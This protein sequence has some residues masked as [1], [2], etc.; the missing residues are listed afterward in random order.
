MENQKT[1]LQNMQFI[2]YGA[3]ALDLFLFIIYL[4]AA[5]NGIIWLKIIIAI[6]AILLS[7]L[8]LGFLY[9]S[10]EMLRPRSIWMSVMAVSIAICLLFSLILNFP[11]PNPYT[12]YEKQ[13]Q[14][15]VDPEA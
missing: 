11:S 5:G 3:L 1:R 9:L 4:I 12:V 2:M 7:V 15:S 13:T 14:G 8:C 6:L 10:K